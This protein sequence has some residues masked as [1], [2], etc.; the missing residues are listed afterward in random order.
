MNWGQDNGHWEPLEYEVVNIQILLQQ[1]RLHST[2]NFDTNSLC[3]C[4][5]RD[6]N[7]TVDICAPA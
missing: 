7:S 3:S 1:F 2:H 4:V 6:S 5:Y